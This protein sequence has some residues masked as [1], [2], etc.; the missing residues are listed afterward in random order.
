MYLNSSTGGEYIAYD[1]RGAAGGSGTAQ[2]ASG[3]THLSAGDYVTVLV[4]QSA[5]GSLNVIP[6][7]TLSMAWLAP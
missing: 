5:A 7:A 4:Q 2:T 6:H 3:V 1:I